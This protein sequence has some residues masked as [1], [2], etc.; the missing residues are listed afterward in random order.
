[1]GYKTITVALSDSKITNVYAYLPYL[2]PR[3]PQKTKER[4]KEKS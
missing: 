4:S 3:T 2:G 1:M